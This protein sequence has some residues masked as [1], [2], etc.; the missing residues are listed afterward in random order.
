M[1][2]IILLTS[3]ISIHKRGTFLYPTLGFDSNT[4]LLKVSD[5]FGN[6]LPE[7]CSEQVAPLATIVHEGNKKISIS[8]NPPC[9]LFC[10]PSNSMMAGCISFNALGG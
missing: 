6:H 8:L 4:N 5:G 3:T 9:S 1:N 2:P 10:K 7:P